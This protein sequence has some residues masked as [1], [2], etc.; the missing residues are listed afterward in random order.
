VTIQEVDRDRFA[1]LTTIQVGH[2]SLIT[3]N[4]LTRL[5]SH[6]ELRLFMTLKNDFDTKRLGGVVVRFTDARRVLPEKSKLQQLDLN[7][8]VA[9]D[10][11]DLFLENN[12]LIIDP[13][14]E[15]LYYN[16][17]MGEFQSNPHTPRIFLD[18]LDEVDR[19]KAKKHSQRVRSAKR[20]L[21]LTFWRDVAKDD[22]LSIPLVKQ[23]FNYQQSL[24]SDILLAPVPFINASELLPVAH[25]M[26]HIGSQLAKGRGQFASYYIVASELLANMSFMEDLKN[27]LMD[28]NRLV[29]LKFKGLDLTRPEREVEADNF[30]DFMETISYISK[31]SPQKAFCLLE[32]GHQLYPS[33]V[34][35]FDIVSS[36][37][38]GY[39]SDGGFTDEHPTYGAWRDYQSMTLRKHSDV[40]GEFGANHGNIPCPCYV[41]KNTR[42]FEDMSLGEWNEYRR[43][44]NTA[45][46][47]LWLGEIANAIGKRQTELARDKLVRSRVKILADLIPRS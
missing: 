14:T 8:K 6:S 47:D 16:Y 29:F 10:R 37:M 18:Y 44:H 40:I 32:T 28:G 45:V 36:S 46:P 42:N 26:N 25:K 9:K 21:H 13:A 31:E 23:Y 43:L 1:R 15:Y 38:N 2:K 11:F 30:K 7:N 33:A 17:E 35:G 27:S 24:D 39:D 4:F 20:S 34:Y 5:S 19:T 3:P 41:C 12:L 22:K